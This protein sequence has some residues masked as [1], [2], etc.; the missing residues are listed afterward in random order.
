MTSPSLL[1]CG[2][3]VQPVLVFIG[4][5]I[6]RGGESYPPPDPGLIRLTFPGYGYWGDFGAGRL[7]R[8]C[9]GNVPQLG[10]RRQVR[11]SL[12]TSSRLRSSAR[13]R[14]NSAT[15]APTPHTPRLSSRPLG[16]SAQVRLGHATPRL[17]QA[18][19]LRWGSPLR[20]PHGCKFVSTSTYVS[21]RKS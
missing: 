11:S 10:P 13:S 7:R 8:D 2:P 18:E 3:S 4:F 5:G 17:E 20:Q 14:S 12:A 6:L 9:R 16:R 1:I 15:T 21:F 19:K